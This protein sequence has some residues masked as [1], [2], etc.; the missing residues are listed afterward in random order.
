[1]EK[2]SAKPSEKAESKPDDSARAKALLEGKPADVKATEAKTTEAKAADTKVAADKGRFVVQFGSF[3]D[4][5][6]SREARQKVE[7]IGMK[8]YAQVIQSGDSKKVRVRVGPFETKA[9]AEKAA[10]KIKKLDL[11]T[12]ILEL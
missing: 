4:V 3:T 1:M 9:E 6:K 10:A 7:K 5:V 8:T 2:A 11:P 12:A